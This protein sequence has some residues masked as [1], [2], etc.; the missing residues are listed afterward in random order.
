MTGIT[1]SNLTAVDYS[2]GTLIIAFRNGGISPCF[3]APGIVMHRTFR[4]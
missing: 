1:S 3:A 4:A 2:A